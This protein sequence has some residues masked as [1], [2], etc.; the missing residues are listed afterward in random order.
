MLA[1][2]IRT[3]V[4]I[5]DDHPIYREGLAR[6]IRLRPELDLVAECPDGAT[7]LERIRTLRP[8]VAVL[9]LGMPGLDGMKVANAISRDRI[10]TRVL[11]VSA[12]AEGKAVYGAVAGGAGG[13]LTKDADRDAI[14]DAISAVARGG[15]VIGTRVQGAL[16]GEIRT[17]APPS[18]PHLTPR[19][20]EVLGMIAR[21]LS[22]PEMADEL[23]LGATTVRSHIQSLY[24]KLNVADRG[25]AVASAM[26]LGLLE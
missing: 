15:T 12:V 7:A 20:Q 16:A 23:I 4:L 25:A 2:R 3:S 9:D 13:Y 18:R 22:A 19:E 8:E 24:E 21:G 10:P 6:V 1:N 17:M 14:C 5:A 11:F 26:R